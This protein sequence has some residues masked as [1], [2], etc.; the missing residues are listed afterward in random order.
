[1]SDSGY[2]DDSLLALSGIQHFAYC[3]RQW[4]LIHLEQQW[5][6]SV[7]TIEGHHLHERV[8]SQL[9]AE[10]RGD[11]L[12]ARSLALVSRKLGLYGVADVVEFIR[13]SDDGPDYQVR[14]PN[15]T[16]MWIARPV[17]YKRGKTKPDDRDEVQ[18]CAQ[19]MCLEEM[20]GVRVS[21]GAIYY[22]MMQRR[23]RVEF[24]AKLR[25]RVRELANAMRR[26]N[27][28]GVTPPPGEIGKCK[29]C[30]LIDVC[31]PAVSGRTTSSV[32]RWITR[33]VD[34]MGADVGGVE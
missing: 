30:S 9:S 14:L 25:D 12:V 32:E 29:L 24:S 7:A 3:P 8:H 13:P 31:L 27:E 23:A 2:D 1:M 16:G 11:T 22:G 34:R 20:L 17:E 10:S 4:A 28:G 33:M 26:V 19:A 15:R 5:T 6:E 21:T 18:L